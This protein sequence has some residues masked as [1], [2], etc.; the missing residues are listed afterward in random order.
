M[1]GMAFQSDTG[2]DPKWAATTSKPHTQKSPR[3]GTLGRTGPSNPATSS[4]ATTSSGGNAPPPDTSRNRTFLTESKQADARCVRLRT[5][6]LT[7]SRGSSASTSGGTPSPR[8]LC[9]KVAVSPAPAGLPCPFCSV[10]LRARI[11][12]VVFRNGQ[13]RPRSAQLRGGAFMRLENIISRLRS[14]ADPPFG[15]AQLERD[16]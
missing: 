10:S 15:A 14:V 1:P 4:P 7:T 16:E 8:V 5:A 9:N 11:G 6:S 3:S 2:A 13:A 12:V